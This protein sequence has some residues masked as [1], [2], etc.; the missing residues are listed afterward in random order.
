MEIQNKEI[1]LGSSA[2]FKKKHTV[3]VTIK[4]EFGIYA[5]SKIEAEARAIEM[6]LGL[7]LGSGYFTIDS[8]EES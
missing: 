1:P 4:P 7:N 6:V 3:K 2:E 8:V 5:K